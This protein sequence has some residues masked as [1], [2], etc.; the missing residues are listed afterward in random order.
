ME[1]SNNQETNKFS[2]YRPHCTNGTRRLLL[3]L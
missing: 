1:Q 3:E 2:L